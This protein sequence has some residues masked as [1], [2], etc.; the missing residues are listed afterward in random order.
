MADKIINS[1]DVWITAKGLKSQ[2][3]LKT[4]DNISLDGV[5]KLR[6]LILEL[7]VHGKLVSQDPSDEPVETLLEKIQKVKKNLTEKGELKKQK[8]LPELSD[9]HKPFAIPET[10]KFVRIG[11][12]TNYGSREQV[13][14]AKISEEEW[15]LELED[16]EKVTSRLLQRIYA[17]DRPPQS[18]R[19]R[20]FKS[21]VIYGK[22]R[23]YLDKVIVADA[24]GLCTT[25]M[26]PLK[27]YDS[28]LPE[29]LR[30]LMKSP[31]FVKYASESTHGMNLPRLGTDKAR[32]AVIP[33]APLNEQHRIV[34]KVNELMDLCDELE[35]RETDHLKSHQLLV[36]TLLGTLT[37]AKDAA[38]FQAAW[39][40]LAQHFDDIFV[41][42]D[43][44]DQLKQTILQLAVMGK[45]VPQDPNDEPASELLNKIEKDRSKNEGKTKKRKQFSAL[46]AEEK[47]YDL[48][49]DWLWCH[50]SMLGEF[51]NGDRSANYP[52][53]SE[54][55]DNGVAWIN[56]GHIEP[57]GTLSISLMNYI[58]LEKNLT[59]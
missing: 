28:I 11:D 52:N 32:L 58:S 3:Q 49:K 47:F 23:P 37:Q 6:E 46:T 45:L 40:R 27:G 13:D 24:D 55:V 10:W 1:F 39:S 44:I 31:F 29:Y 57:D 30:L 2:G 14:P 36:E 33:I 43:S 25:E 5:A 4:I 56:T 35:K 41:T 9:E 48:P 51:I 50:F 53:K 12:V 19:N 34:A 26:I 22:L 8:A 42:A 21:D 59:H 18:S 16:V 20:F 7:A 54:Y 15:V 17:K 38:E